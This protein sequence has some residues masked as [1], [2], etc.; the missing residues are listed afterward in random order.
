MSQIVQFRRPEAPA[1]TSN[2]FVDCNG[3]PE[4]H[5]RRMEAL[6]YVVVEEPAQRTGRPPMRSELTR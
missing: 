5:V 2:V 4:P 6:G 3:S 1:G